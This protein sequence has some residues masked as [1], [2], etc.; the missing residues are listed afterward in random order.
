MRGWVGESKMKIVALQ[1]TRRLFVL[2][3]GWR[4]LAGGIGRSG[5]RWIPGPQC[6]SLSLMSGS[7]TYSGDMQR[8]PESEM[9]QGT[10]SFLPL[11]PTLLPEPSSVLPSPSV[12]S[13][14]QFLSTPFNH[15]SS[16]QDQSHAYK[17]NISRPKWTN[18]IAITMINGFAYRKIQCNTF[19]SSPCHV[20][21]LTKCKPLRKESEMKEAAL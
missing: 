13:S 16:H 7:A 12:S 20:T 9:G 1:L 2:S 14:S 4:G 3:Q 15:S 11:P 8:S 10:L 6:P 5:K 18:F 19:P 21:P 17:S